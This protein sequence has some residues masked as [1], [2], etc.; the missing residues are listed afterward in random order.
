LLLLKTTLN[1]QKNSM[2]KL[3]L[4]L[5]TLG[6]IVAG[7]RADFVYVTS[8]VS[9]CAN[10]ADCPSG[11]NGDLNAN[12][13]LI[14]DE[15]SLGFFT[16][17]VSLAPGKPATAGA[18]AFSFSFTNSTPDYGIK[19]S[20]TLGITGG[21]YRVY[22]VF[23]SAA[24]NVSTNVLLAV[25]NVDGCTLSFTNNID[26]FRA[27]YGVASG[28][29]NTWQ[30][31]G[32]LTNNPDT[33]TP[34]ITFYYQS[35]DVDAGSQR[36]LLVDTFLF[37]S[38]PCTDIAAPGI[39]GVYKVGDTSVTVTG[40]DGAATAVRVYQYDAGAWTLVGQKT[41]G[42]TAGNNTVTVSGL[43]KGGQLAATQTVGG[44]ES[45]LW[46][47]PTG[48][49][50]GT[51]NP[52]LR[53]ALS[54]RETPST[55]PVGVPGVTSGGST[56][57]LHFLGVTN[58]LSGAPGYPGLVIYPSNSVWQTLTFDAGI[59]T[60]GNS[61]NAAG[62]PQPGPGYN[63]NET[64]AIQVYAYRT[65]PENGVLIY[66]QTGAES[67]VVTS[68]DV[69]TVNWTWAAV[70]GA[71]GY[72]LLRNYGGG[73]Y[74][75]SVDV[76]GATTFSDANT[77]W[78]ADTTVTPNRTQTGPSVKWNTATGDPDPTGTVYGLRSNWYTIDAIAFVIDDLTS[79]GPH[80]IY[81]DSIQNGAT[82]FYNMEPAPAGITDY[83]FR[84]PSFSGSTSGNLA[85]APNS[86]VIAN[87][88]AFDGTKSL[89]VQWAWNGTTT[90]KWLRFTTSGVGNPQVNVNDPISIRFL[91]VPDGGTYPAAP[92]APTLNVTRS[93]DQTVLNWTGGHRLLTAVEVPGAY[94]NVPQ[95]LSPNVYSNVILGGFLG[96]WTNTYPEPTRFF[97][98]RD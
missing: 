39:S 47:V 95:T 21:V 20:P 34:T 5:I 17:A 1:P 3:A 42:I 25:T 30:F 11:L 36:R 78:I 77:A 8:T 61:T 59:K 44:Q 97:R 94:T 93:G 71:D 69:F 48:V 80:D 45:C 53:L 15:N 35:G 88:A 72:R 67:A 23:S 87:N 79:V 32:F 75:D 65:V 55:G 50:V 6:V 76:P 86:A 7:A 89:R 14:Y 58:R 29:L 66:S 2:K 54:L 68:N 57:N 52:R 4:V 12:F 40:V 90:T 64:V 9:N 28:G 18:R 60:L 46:G 49:T 92:P 98:L 62:T 33:S 41:S 51:P 70:P 73:G 81:I 31:L 63:A 22:H 37:A 56:A 96:P 24:G 10:V 43:V 38:D 74:F 91:Y 19:I 82:T 85:G 16:T 84:A 13:G 27:A 83:A 26:K